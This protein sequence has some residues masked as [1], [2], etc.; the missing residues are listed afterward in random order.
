[1]VFSRN[2][3]AICEP[4]H[5]SKSFSKQDQAANDLAAKKIE[6]AIKIREAAR[7]RQSK[8]A[9]FGSRATAWRPDV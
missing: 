3:P 6:I 5:T 8:A 7:L 1:M 9:P 4:V 2:K